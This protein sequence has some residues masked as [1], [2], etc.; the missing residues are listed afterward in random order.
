LDGIRWVIDPGMQGY[1]E[2][3]KTGFDLW[4]KKQ[5]SERWT[6]LN[7]NNFGHSGLTL[8]HE[9]YRVDGFAPLIDF[10]DSEQPEAAFDLTALYGKNATQ[11]TRRFIKDGP[12]SLLIHDLVEVSD[13]TRQITWQVMTTARVEINPGGAL[14]HQ[15]GEVLHLENLSHPGAEISLVS[16][17]PPPLKLDRQIEGLKRL[18]IK[19]PPA[20]AVDGRIDLKV[21]LSKK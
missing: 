5:D 6:L 9:L 17:D 12:E 8:N 7:K 18:E 20:A 11:V 2:L 14:L 16:L 10:K 1:H 15:A 13:K 3:E 21:R 19:I 4:G